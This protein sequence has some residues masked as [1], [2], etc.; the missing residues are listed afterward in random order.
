MRYGGVIAFNVHECWC[1]LLSGR[2][3]VRV[4]VRVTGTGTG[5]GTGMGWGY[6]EG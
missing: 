2:D 5:T 1:P 3:R 4:R 6:R